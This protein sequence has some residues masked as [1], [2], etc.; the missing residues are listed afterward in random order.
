MYNCECAD[1]MKSKSEHSLVAHKGLYL[2]Y[3]HIVEMFFALNVNKHDLLN[4]VLFPMVGGQPLV[5]ILH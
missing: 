5:Q 2:E 3:C 4:L 1:P